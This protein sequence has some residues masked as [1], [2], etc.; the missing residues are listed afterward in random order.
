MDE[1]TTLE[2]A[3]FNKK[4]RNAMLALAKQEKL[5]AKAKEQ[6]LIAHN[7]LIKYFLDR[8][9]EKDNPA[10]KEVENML[11][12]T[13]RPPSLTELIVAEVQKTWEAEIK[14]LEEE[15]RKR[16]DEA[17]KREDEVRKREAEAKKREAEAKKRE[18]EARQE[19]AKRDEKARQEIA[20]RDAEIAKLNAALIE[21]ALA[22]KTK[23]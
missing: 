17:R 6:M 14:K 19:I 9:I 11:V 10:R 23:E 21:L 15:A 5:S 8:Y 22:S 3:K 1:K 16:E 12:V 2:F 20:K 13:E 7:N 18:A 4:I